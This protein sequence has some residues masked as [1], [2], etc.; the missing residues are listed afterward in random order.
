MIIKGF[1]H[2]PG[3]N[4]G[5]TSLWNISKFY[6][7]RYP[8]HV[9]FGLSSGLLFFYMKGGFGGASY[10]IGGRNPL[11]VEDF[12]DNIGLDWKW[13]SYEDF[14]E[15]IIKESIKSGIPVL[16]RTDLFYLPYY[17]KPVHFPGHEL[18]IFGYEEKNLGEKKRVFLLCQIVLFLNHRRFLVK[19]FLLLWLPKM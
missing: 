4:C 13:Q 17:P 19:I 16:A 3:K 11:L 18:V 8:E 7:N 14:P 5:S 15:N 1:E 9:I 6:G 2:S 10:G 12:F